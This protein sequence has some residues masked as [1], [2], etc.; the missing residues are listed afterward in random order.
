M[1]KALLRL[2]FGIYAKLLSPILHSFGMSRCIYLPTCSEYAY[3]AMLRFGVFRGGA[4]A[5][6]RLGRC[7]PL[8]TGGYDPVPER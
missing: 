7:H 5:L 4:M 2:I 6:R 3:V 1:K 8:A